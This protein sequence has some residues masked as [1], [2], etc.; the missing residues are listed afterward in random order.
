MLVKINPVNSVILSFGMKFLSVIIKKL[1][2][3][4]DLSV[5]IPGG[6]WLE[7]PGSLIKGKVFDWRRK[8]SFVF[9]YDS[10]Q[11]DQETIKGSNLNK[12]SNLISK[13]DNLAN[14]ISNVLDNTVNQSFV[15]WSQHSTCRFIT[16]LYSRAV[17]WIF[18][19]TCD[20]YTHL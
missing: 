15:D 2:E 3:N 13:N 10:Y 4:A 5:E 18:Y 7:L 8:V 20:S 16:W 11:K 19:I 9:T 1:K 6:N 17:Y 14:G 12:L